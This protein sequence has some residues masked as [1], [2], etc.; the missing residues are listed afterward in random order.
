MNA[1]KPEFLF[2]TQAEYSQLGGNTPAIQSPI[3]MYYLLNVNKNIEHQILGSGSMP[4]KK[5]LLKPDELDLWSQFEPWA[6]KNQ[7]RPKD[8]F[9]S[10]HPYLSDLYRNVSFR[11]NLSTKICPQKY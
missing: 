1:S 8:R 6:A 3:L 2:L 10:H 4:G 11:I 9:T 7:P 5:V